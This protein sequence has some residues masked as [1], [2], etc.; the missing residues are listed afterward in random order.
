MNKLNPLVGNFVITG[1]ENCC[2]SGH[3]KG[4]IGLVIEIRK[5]D[6]ESDGYE[7]WAGGKTWIHCSKCCQVISLKD[8]QQAIEELLVGIL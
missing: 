4:T 3:K 2:S 8:N 6:T 1:K 5:Y 7:V